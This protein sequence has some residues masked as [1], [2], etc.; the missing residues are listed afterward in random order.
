MK[1]Y[2]PLAF[3]S[4]KVFRVPKEYQRT[5]RV[6]DLLHR[7]LARLI[8]FELA[9]PRVKLVTITAVKVS[10]DLAYAK[11][12]ITQHKEEAEIAGTIKILNKA[13]GF[14]RHQLM[15]IVELRVIPQLTFVYDSSIAHGMHLSNLIDQA[16]E[17]D[18]K[19]T[20]KKKT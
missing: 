4:L 14:L 13:S 15:D 8:Q 18:A 3:S 5:D 7:K 20:K 11:V 6:A 12:Y 1:S 9:D 2:F 16:V 10:R 19:I 17:E